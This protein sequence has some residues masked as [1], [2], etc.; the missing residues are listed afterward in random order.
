MKTPKVEGLELPEEVLKE[1]FKLNFSVFS[2]HGIKYVDIGVGGA[3]RITG[4]NDIDKH[5]YLTETPI[6]VAIQYENENNLYCRVTIANSILKRWV[7]VFEMEKYCR[8]DLDGNWI[9]LYIAKI[10]E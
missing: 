7:S 6:T 5:S 9:K 3:I 8:Y 4:Y 1:I 10:Y 2:G